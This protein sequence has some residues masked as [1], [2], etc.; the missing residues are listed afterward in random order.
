[1][2]GTRKVGSLTFNGPC[3]GDHGSIILSKTD[4]DIKN[5][6]KLFGGA[7]AMFNESFY[8]VNII[9]AFDLN[10]NNN[11]DNNGSNEM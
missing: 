5:E 10:N 1:M 9:I 7:Q 8:E 6:I 4:T 2:H 11:N 3:D